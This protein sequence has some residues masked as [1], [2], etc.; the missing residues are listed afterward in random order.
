[1]GPFRGLSLWQPMNGRHSYTIQ[2][3]ARVPAGAYGK[4]KLGTQELVH[5]QHYIHYN[6]QQTELSSQSHIQ[7]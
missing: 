3:I 5:G 7:H 6:V 2:P 4:T 1:M